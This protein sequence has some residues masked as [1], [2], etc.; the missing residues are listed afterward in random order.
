MS[1]STAH[2]G[3]QTIA[4][5]EDIFNIGG[6]L[7]IISIVMRANIED[8]T[9]LEIECLAKPNDVDITSVE[10][11]RDTVIESSCYEVTIKRIEPKC[12]FDLMESK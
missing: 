9:T 1:I 5:M 6:D 4:M 2:S 10:L 7:P 3:K 11:S 8:A 12:D